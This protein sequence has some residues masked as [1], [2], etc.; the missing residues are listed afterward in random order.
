M[1]V[2]AQACTYSHD[3]RAPLTLEM[4]A[5]VGAQNWVSG[6]ASGVIQHSNGKSPNSME[7]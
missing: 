6:V 1:R 4:F 2:P 3:P 7:V 5:P